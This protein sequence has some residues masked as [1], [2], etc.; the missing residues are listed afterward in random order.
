[1]E[2]RSWEK[3]DTLLSILTLLCLC[4][5]LLAQLELPQTN[6]V[7]IQGQTAVL[8]ASYIG[9]DPS[10]ATIIWTYLDQS[11]II[12][13]YNNG[14]E[15]GTQYK[16]RVGFV[17]PM[18]SNNLSIYI[19]NTSES[20]SGVY[21]C[22]VLSSGIAGFVKQLT[23]NVTVPPAMP[24]CKLQG[25]PEVKANVT[26]SCFSSSGKPVPKYKW[27]KTSPTSEFFFSPML[28]EA[29]GTL[30]LN[31]LSSNMSGKYECTASNSAGEAK[32]Y[33]NLEVITS[34]NAGVIAGATVGALVGLILI[35][36]VIVFLWTRKRKDTE[37]DLANDIKE[38]AQAPK[39]V[40]WAKSGTGSDIISKNGTLS[41]VRSSPL[42]HDTH[43][44]H[45]HHYPI[46]Q[47]TSDTASI[48]T[49][50]TSYQPRP[51]GIS[52]TPEHALPGY[53]TNAMAPRNPPAPSSSNGGS[54]PRTA[55][56]Q[57]P[58]SRY[59]PAPSGVS[60]ANLSRMGGVPIMVPAQNQAG[61]LV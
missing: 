55:A 36:L 22:Q 15:I 53:N 5:G 31:N 29:A 7:V 11:E 61:S 24:V 28:N 43:D 3:L 51:A 10:S 50:S 32:C 52:S 57:P 9:G 40:S 17:H 56:L 58:T 20:D 48:I 42:P 59:V 25:K 49:G 46:T 4:P 27:S 16:G 37:D 44:H 13:R 2:S 45:S 34:T 39:R 60:A 26:L 33:I 1:M 14:L 8:Q 30:K 47:P 21:I 35:I 41:S 38:D 18:P 54:L 23:L 12:I 19:N 6:V